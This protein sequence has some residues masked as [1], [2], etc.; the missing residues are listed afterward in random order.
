MK[1][2]NVR[3]HYVSIHPIFIITVTVLS[4]IFSY[5]FQFV[6]IAPS[7]TAHVIYNCPSPPCEQVRWYVASELLRNQW[8]PTLDPSQKD[9]WI[10]CWQKSFLGITGFFPW[11]LGAICPWLNLRT[12]LLKN[13]SAFFCCFMSHHGPI[14]VVNLVNCWCNKQTGEV[15]TWEC[16]QTL[17]IYGISATKLPQ[18]VSWSLDFFK[19]RFRSSWF[20]CNC[21]CKLCVSPYDVLPWNFVGFLVGLKWRLVEHGD[22]GFFFG[23]FPL[24]STM[25]ETET[26]FML[27]MK[28]TVEPTNK[29]L[30]SL[31]PR[32]RMGVLPSKEHA[33][34]IWTQL[35]FPGDF[36]EKLCQI[37][38]SPQDLPPRHWTALRM[39]GT[40]EVLLKGLLLRYCEGIKTILTDFCKLF[41][42]M[43]FF[44]LM[45]FCNDVFE[46]L[47][48]LWIVDSWGFCNPN[49]LKWFRT[50]H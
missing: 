25:D 19:P 26:S 22:G 42:M 44:R 41:V 31:R 45:L 28:K 35:H 23:T 2:L 4:I 9:W 49:R 1:K 14:S 30:S 10:F 18:L 33:A 17:F 27:F 43:V 37:P 36:H 46:F 21:R 48:L 47:P 7:H 29:P 15:T 39:G 3:S 40:H 6:S 34:C 12:V 8:A 50:N 11:I 16:A 32:G 5:I 24:K 38:P 13:C 20:E